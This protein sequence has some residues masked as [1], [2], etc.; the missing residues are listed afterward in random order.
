MPGLVGLEGRPVLITGAASG[1]GHA[2]ALRLGEEGAIV[3]IIDLDGAGAEATAALIGEAGGEAYA[4]AADITDAAA[5]ES[6]VAAFTS[7]AGRIDGLVNNAGWDH[8][9]D[10]LD[11]EPELW[12]KIIEINLLGP[13]NVSRSVLTRMRDQ[14]AGRVVSIASDAG[15]VGSSG[16][17]VYAACKGGIVAFSKS[18]AR[19]LAKNG[20]TLNVVSPGP[21]DTPLFASFDPTGKIA[22]AL[23]R[24]IPMRRLAQPA[25]FPGI[26]AF[27]L[28]DEAGFITGQTI[29]VSGGLTMHG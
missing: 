6:A 8:A 29:S 1:I 4:Y 20:I 19:E 2:T 23:E 5:V 26:I 22:A 7:A 13:L 24:A 16:E 27:L 3:G 18:V 10:F 17:A 21:T 11:T 12:R 15:R 14:G 25:D 9:A 28:S